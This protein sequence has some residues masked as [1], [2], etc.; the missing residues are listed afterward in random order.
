MTTDHPLL[1]VGPKVLITLR[2]RPVASHCRLFTCVC[3]LLTLLACILPPLELLVKYACL[4]TNCLAKSR[5]LISISS[6]LNI[7]I[8]AGAWKPWYSVSLIKPGSSY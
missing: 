3:H 4:H 2:V 7:T 8:R 5:L 1:L 6:F